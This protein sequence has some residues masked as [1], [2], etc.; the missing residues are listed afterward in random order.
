MKKKPTQPQIAVFLL[1][2]AGV[3]GVWL[4]TLQPDLLLYWLFGL[5]F[6]FILQ[7]FWICFVSAA[8]DPIIMGSTERFRA[9]LIGILVA[10]CGVTVIKYLS[11]G[12]LYMLGV[13]AVSL[14]LMIGAFLFGLGMI[15]AGC[16]SSGM[17]VRMAE[18][19]TVHII[20]LICIIIGY[21]VANSHYQALWAPF[22]ARAPLI[23]FPEK[24]GWVGGVGI[25]IAIILLFYLASRK[26]EQRATSSD[27]TIYLKGAILLALLNIVHVLVL[28]N[29]WSVTGAFFW[30]G[31]LINGLLGSS[32][33]L[34]AQENAYTVAVAPNLRNIGLFVGALA[35]VLLSAKFTVKKIRSKKQ[36]GKSIAGGLLM[37]YGACLAGGCNISAFFMG[38]ASLSLSAWVFMIFLFAGAFVGVKILYRML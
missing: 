25:H 12:S 11:D 10:S 21:L 26:Y 13:S 37:G 27:N 20:T 4:F 2:L 31:E 24:C 9:I 8:S 35:S 33:T 28:K 19:Y 17:F 18:G 1:L 30:F 16:C 14:P 22:V 32:G 3:F 6:G 7:R 15:L 29:V 36:I 38:A 23:F 5:G 34:F